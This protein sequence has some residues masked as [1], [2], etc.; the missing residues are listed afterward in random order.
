MYVPPGSGKKKNANNLPTSV[1]GP[2]GI[3]SREIVALPPGVCM[4][5]E[6]NFVK[7]SVSPRAVV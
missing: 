1:I 5:E 3:F 6:I 4:T 7:I 2:G